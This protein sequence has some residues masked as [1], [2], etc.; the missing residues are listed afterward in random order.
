MRAEYRQHHG[1]KPRFGDFTAQLAPEITQ[2]PRVAQGTMP[3]AAG[4]LVTLHHGI[5]IVPGILG[6]QA[7]RKLDRAK[8]WRGEARIQPEKFAAQKRVVET[9]VMRHEHGPLQLLAHG[10]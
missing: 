6:K 9:R 5:E 10:R 2:Y 8:N 3:G 1:G 7:P 4:E